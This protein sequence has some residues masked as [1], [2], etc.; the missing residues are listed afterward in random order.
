MSGIIYIDPQTMD[1]V[2]DAALADFDDTLNDMLD[3]GECDDFDLVAWQEIARQFYVNGYVH[4]AMEALSNEDFADS[5]S[6]MDE[7][8][9]YQREQEDKQ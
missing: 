9:K 6:L 3:N 7:E 1:E 4:G 5:I 8:V 2:T